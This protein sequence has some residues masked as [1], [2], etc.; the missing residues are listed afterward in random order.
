ML[1]PRGIN[2]RKTINSFKKKRKV[3]RSTNVHLH[4]LN[5]LKSANTHNNMIIYINNEDNNIC[6]NTDNNLCD[7]TENNNNDDSYSDP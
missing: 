3:K 4:L 6:D 1:K 7:N 5:G 2:V